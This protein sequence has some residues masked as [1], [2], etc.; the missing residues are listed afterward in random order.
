MVRERSNEQ[1]E[2][3]RGDYIISNFLVANNVTV[4]GQI[5]SSLTLA[6]V[7]SNNTDPSAFLLHD[8]PLHPQQTAI[9]QMKTSLQ[10][11]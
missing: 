4:N 6:L 1:E 2:K 7:S 3:L 8:G 9:A 5:P 10:K 11:S